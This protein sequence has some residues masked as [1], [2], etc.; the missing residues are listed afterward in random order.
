MGQDLGRL[1]LRLGVGGLLLLHGIA[2]LRHGIGFV[3]E[4]MHAHGLPG[5]FA[6]GVYL[7]EVVGPLLLLL[8][9][10]TRGAALLCAADMVV[11]LL[12]VHLGS[13]W[14]LGP[15]GGWALELPAL[16]LVGSLAVFFLGAGRYG[17]GKG[18]LS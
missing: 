18:R 8:G 13:L 7:G 5:F 16:Y 12:L 2:K 3:V 4:T 15:A 6:Y 11:A 9:L 1:L 14:Q 10:W 17:A